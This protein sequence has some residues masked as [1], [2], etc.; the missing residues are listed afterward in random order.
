MKCN[1]KNTELKKLQTLV[2]K[3]YKN[4]SDIDKSRCELDISKDSDEQFTKSLTEVEQFSGQIKALKEILN[5][6]KAKKKKLIQDISL[7][8]S[9]FNSKESIFTEKLKKN[10]HAIE[11]SEQTLA[12]LK[13]NIESLIFDFRNQEKKLEKMQQEVQ[14]LSEQ[15]D[16]IY[17]QCKSIKEE[18]GLQREKMEN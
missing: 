18:I 2:D 7:I 3:Y 16:E 6:S 12:N 9:E 13:V 15:R 11:I 4:A 17:R 10:Q 8:T 5:K 1:I 14:S